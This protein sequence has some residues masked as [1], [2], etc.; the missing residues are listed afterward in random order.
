[1][2]R[3]SIS[4]GKRFYFIYYLFTLFIFTCSFSLFEYGFLLLSSLLFIYFNYESVDL[5]GKKGIPLIDT[6][7]MYPRM[8]RIDEVC[9]HLYIFS[10][11]STQSGYECFVIMEMVNSFYVP[12]SFLLIFCMLEE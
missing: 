7:K 5:F 11:P 2:T 8:L 10:N 1:M 3:T 6:F 12:Y 9:E 4:L